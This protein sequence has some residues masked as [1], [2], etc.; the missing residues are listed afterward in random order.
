MS[1]LLNK[2]LITQT[3]TAGY[4]PKTHG[5]AERC[6]G[7]LKSK[8]TSY[9]FQTGMYQKLFLVL[10]MPLPDDAYTFGNG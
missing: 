5:T 9:L 6:V 7:I 3:K 10:E 1:E 4:D 2:N 8:A